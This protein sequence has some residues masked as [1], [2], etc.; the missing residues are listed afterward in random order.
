M[1]NFLPRD[2]RHLVND[3][4]GR[5]VNDVV[6]H[7]SNDDGKTENIFDV[8]LDRSHE[9]HSLSN[10]LNEILYHI[11]PMLWRRVDVVCKYVVLAA[12]LRRPWF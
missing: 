6:G 8:T 2:P 5:D 10:F 1:G 11:L 7:V 3:S 4:K 9:V 12:S